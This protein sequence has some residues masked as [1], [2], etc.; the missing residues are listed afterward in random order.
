MLDETAQ[1]MK[2]WMTKN[3]LKRLKGL[4]ISQRKGILRLER[5]AI[6]EKREHP[7]LTR[8]GAMLIASQHMRHRRR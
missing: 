3:D 6:H 1:R 4:P 7:Q 5:M 8:A 2:H